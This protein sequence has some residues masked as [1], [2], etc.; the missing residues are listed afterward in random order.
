MRA[1]LR[2]T[3]F[4]LKGSGS[5]VIPFVTVLSISGILPSAGSMVA[6]EKIC[7]KAQK[8]PTSDYK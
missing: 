8:T 6:L 3:N 1:S 7:M 4:T 5:E 2:L